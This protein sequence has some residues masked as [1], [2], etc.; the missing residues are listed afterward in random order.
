MNVLAFPDA[1]AQI[2]SDLGFP[3]VD[4]APDCIV[5][6][7]YDCGSLLKIVAG[8]DFDWLV[9]PWGLGKPVYDPVDLDA[10]LRDLI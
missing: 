3:V 6:K 7:S 2:A 4:S 8:D 10:L 5:I 9:Y 1:Y